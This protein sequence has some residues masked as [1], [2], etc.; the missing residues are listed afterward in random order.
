MLAGALSPDLAQAAVLFAVP[1][2]IVSS[3]APVTVI[4][5]V[6][7]IVTPILSLCP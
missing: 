2:L 1:T 5:S 6:N 3:G 7:V 4:G